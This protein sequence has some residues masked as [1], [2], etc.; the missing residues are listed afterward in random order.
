MPLKRH[1]TPLFRRAVR[2]AAASL[3]MLLAPLA[4]GHAADRVIIASSDGKLVDANAFC[5]FV[6]TSSPAFVSASHSSLTLRKSAVVWSIA[7]ARFASVAWTRWSAG[8]E[9]RS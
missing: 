4:A 8:T 2:A 6:A 9:A 5:A 7:F 3:P 1:S